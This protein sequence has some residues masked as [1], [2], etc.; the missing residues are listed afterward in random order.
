M[1]VCYAIAEEIICKAQ[2]QSS[3]QGKIRTCTKQDA[4]A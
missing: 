2:G 3:T 4:T 1:Q